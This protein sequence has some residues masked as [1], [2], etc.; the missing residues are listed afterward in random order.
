MGFPFF[1]R[2]Q[3]L[4]VFHEP[5]CVAGQIATL[6]AE[7]DDTPVKLASARVSFL[8]EKAVVVTRPLWEARQF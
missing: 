5:D 7:R 4:G 2:D 6:S 3:D 1:D 8:P